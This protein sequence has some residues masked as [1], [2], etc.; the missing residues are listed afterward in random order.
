M[1]PI[2]GKAGLITIDGEY[3]RKTRKMLN[4]AFSTANLDTQVAGMI[5]ETTVFIKLLETSAK[6]GKVLKLIQELPV[7][8]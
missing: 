2:L 4:P 5:E 8:S 3:W 1:R 6:E 7:S